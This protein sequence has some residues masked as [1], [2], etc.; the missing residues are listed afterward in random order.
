M[1]AIVDV[2]NGVQ[3]EEVEFFCDLQGRVKFFFLGGE[4]GL[5]VFWVV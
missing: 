3:R 5:R 2:Y 1:S 4:R